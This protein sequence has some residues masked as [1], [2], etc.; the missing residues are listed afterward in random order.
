MQHILYPALRGDYWIDEMKY[1]G[2]MPEG[3]R[4]GPVR[5]LP[6]VEQVLEGMCDSKREQL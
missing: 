6:V 5:L 1:D 2:C 3:P 4:K